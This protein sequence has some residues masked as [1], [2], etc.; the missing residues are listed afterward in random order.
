MLGTHGTR[1]CSKRDHQG[2][3]LE[4]ILQETSACWVLGKG[5]PG[6][7]KMSGM[8][9]DT[10]RRNP[11]DTEASWWSQCKCRGGRSLEWR[12]EAGI[13][14][15]HP[16]GLLA[17]DDTFLTRTAVTQLLCP[18]LT[19]ALCAEALCGEKMGEGKLGP[20]WTFGGV[21][22]VGK[23]HHLLSDLATNVRC[24]GNEVSKGRLKVRTALIDTN[25]E[26]KGKQRALR[27][28]IT[29]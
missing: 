15:R 25:F 18:Q 7:W 5:L 27:E 2:R 10:G 26:R 1:K 28:G 12:R 6:T 17:S 14:Q 20:H 11:V 9:S 13:R 23:R 21:C 19:L 4:N 29:I 3:N 8:R 22:L 24:G 16:G